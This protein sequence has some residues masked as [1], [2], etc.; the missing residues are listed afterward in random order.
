MTG[1]Y[2]EDP[3]VDM[4][5]ELLLPLLN[6]DKGGATLVAYDLND[7]KGTLFSQQLIYDFIY[8]VIAFIIIYAIMASHAESMFIAAFAFLQMFR[9]DCMG[10]VGQ[11][12]R[13]W[14]MKQSC[15][16][17]SHFQQL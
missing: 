4:H 10:G 11:R 5:T 2:D 16:R 15:L 9:C 17:H 6:T 1:N 13:V 14:I 12:S 7:I 8:V 3:M